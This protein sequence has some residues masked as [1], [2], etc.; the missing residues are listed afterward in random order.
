MRR[1]KSSPEGDA[2]LTFRVIGNRVHVTMVKG[3]YE[4]DPCFVG[5]GNTVREAIASLSSCVGVFEDS[6]AR[7]FLGL[8]PDVDEEGNEE[9]A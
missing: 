1:M 4:K 7:E 6:E 9:G 5:A 2:D 8:V 3:K